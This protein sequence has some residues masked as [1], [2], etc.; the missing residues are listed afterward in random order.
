V[1]FA[2]GIYGYCF[3]RRF[4]VQGCKL[5]PLYDVYSTVSKLAK[6]PRA[7]HL[8][9]ILVCPVDSLAELSARRD[10]FFDLAAAL[11][12]CEQ[13]WVVL[14]NACELRR[15]ENP[16]KILR[17]DLVHELKVAIP[18]QLA[19]GA[20]I[21]CNPI[22]PTPGH[23]LLPDSFAVNSR[24]RFLRLVL[25]RLSDATFEK[26][27]G[28][29]SAFFRNV[30]ILRLRERYIDISYF[31]IFT[32]LE[33]LSRRSSRVNNGGNLWKPLHTFLNGLG[34]AISEEE[35]KQI[36]ASRNAL[37]HQ[38][39]FE[40]SWFDKTTGSRRPIK[41]TQLPNID[42]LFTDVLLKVMR[43]RDPSINW[44]RW[45]DRQGFIALRPLD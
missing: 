17:A 39:E 7:F 20:D 36:A 31:F 25:K 11:C 6:D 8:T 41:I 18:S 35:A 29:R 13:Q 27:V 30:E 21:F 37:L 9:G 26:Q 15:G 12:F 4:T 45:R 1:S 22:R 24:I 34:F 2:V 5:I 32:G 43:F 42:L 40:G 10:F 19:V 33:R 3:T 28:F 38:G 44:N 23:C 16:S 14:S